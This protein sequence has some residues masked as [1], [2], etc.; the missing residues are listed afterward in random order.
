MR[1]DELKIG[2]VYRGTQLYNG[3]TISNIIVQYTGMIHNTVGEL[4]YVW[5]A[6]DQTMEYRTYGGV[7]MEYHEITEGS[8]T[9][10]EY[11]S[12]ILQYDFE[13]G[14]PI[15]RTQRTEHFPIY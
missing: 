5:C 8:T 11:F 12:R 7:T 14:S 6:I 1:L 9:W 10:E 3:E 15:Q 13:H 2:K 4:S